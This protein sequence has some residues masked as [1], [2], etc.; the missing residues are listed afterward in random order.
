MSEKALVLDPVRECRGNLRLPGSKSLSNRSLLLAA[1]AQGQTRL[2]NVLRSD[3]TRYM[4]NALEALGVAITWENSTEG[5]ICVVQGC[6]GF[7][8]AHQADLFLGNAG[9]AMRPLTAALCLGQGTYHLS[10]EPRMMER[11]IGDLVDALKNLGADIYYKQKKGF[12]PLLIQAHGLQGGRV[13]VKG[14][15]SSQFLTALLMAAPLAQEPVTIQV[16]GELISK[17]YIRITL[18]EMARFGVRVNA[19]EDFSAFVVPCQSYQTPGS[20]LVEGDASAASYFLAAGALAQGP[21]RVLGVGRRSV[22]GDVRFADVLTQMGAH[23][24]WGDDWIEV[25]QGELRGIDLDCNHIPDAAMTLVPLAL[26]AEGPTTIR[27]V[28]SWRVK[29]TDRLAAM[30]TELKKVGADVEEGSDYLRIIP[31]I[32]QDY[33][34]AHIATYNDHRMAMSFALL[35]LGGVPV[36]ILDPG[37]VAKTFPDYFAELAKLCLLG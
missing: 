16:E 7:F 13:S 12:P 37:C 6:G 25:R 33:N 21:V 11:P 5:E 23:V 9:T 30:A 14:D 17:P 24:T 28:A 35:S 32:H 3:D 4:L 34:H 31:R 1:L 2:R 20:V 8:P 22:Q 18:E 36:T 27:N 26:F 19:E 10:G 15:V 29:E